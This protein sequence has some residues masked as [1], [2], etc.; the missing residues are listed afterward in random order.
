MPDLSSPSSPSPPPSPGRAVLSAD[1]EARREIEEAMRSSPPLEDRDEAPPPS[2][3]DSDDS[4]SLSP[5]GVAAGCLS[6]PLP[7]TPRRPV[8]LS[9]RNELDQAE[10]RATHA[11]LTPY[12]RER[13]KD[14][15]KMTPMAREVEVFIA[16]CAL[17]NKLNKIVAA[18]PPFFVGPALLE[19]IKSFAVA[20][21]LSPKLSAYKG[22]NLARD[23][24]IAIVKKSGRHLPP[25]FERDHH[26]QKELRGVV[27]Y[28]L[29]QVRSTMKTKVM[30]VFTAMNAS[31]S[32]IQVAAALS[33]NQTI[34]DLATHAVT[35]TQ[36]RVTVTLAARLALL[37]KVMV[38]HKG[39]T[40]WD[41]VDAR[42]QL[43]RSTTGGD[44]KKIDKTFTTYLD[45]DR[46]KYGIDDGYTLDDSNDM[47]DVL[48]A[49]FDGDMGAN[50]TS[51]T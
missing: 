44:A 22:G 17:D 33:D 12:Q 4:G 2:E 47:D 27:S 18:I 16:I 5:G 32:F 6:E 50:N 38:D 21:L 29:T 8:T 34:F 9:L 48:Q 42:L 13:T 39:A 10:R 49:N 37:R 51:E 23:H 43:I 31:D 19:N 25:D 20:V 14:L 40:Y 28:E 3:H 30:P 1:E 45:A 15:V 46:K 35:G 41:K 24:V 7:A 26:A 36:L 11:K